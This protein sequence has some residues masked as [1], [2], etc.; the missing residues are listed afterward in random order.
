MATIL[1]SDFVAGNTATVT[2]TNAKFTDVATKTASL[3]SENVRSESID[4]W[5]LDGTASM[6]KASGRQTTELAAFTH[7]YLSKANSGT[8]PH[9]IQK[10]DGL[11]GNTNMVLDIGQLQT[12]KN[13][14]VLRVYWNVEVIQQTLAGDSDLYTTGSYSQPSGTFWGVWLQWSTNGS[15]WTNVPNQGDFV[16][17]TAG[18]LT[19]EMLAVSNTQTKAF[20]PIPHCLF[21]VDK[22]L[23][24]DNILYKYPQGSNEKYTCG[25]AWFHRPTTGAELQ[26]RY[27]RLVLGGI[28]QSTNNGATPPVSYIADF[29]SGFAPVGVD[30]AAVQLQRVYLC[31]LHLRG[32]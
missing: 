18:P 15:S 7:N 28:F 24:T 30:D 23:G 32:S 17:T 27:F 12:V 22:S 16:N 14:D 11:G 3:D 6:V 1:N 29:G 9:V 31:A 20:M 2:D 4:L 19:T 13:Y 26:Y 8:A 10:S 25:S 21:Y 5:H